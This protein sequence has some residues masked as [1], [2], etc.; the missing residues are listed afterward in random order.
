V[1][2]ANEPTPLATVLQVDPIYVELTASSTDILRL[3]QEL[4]SGE[5][6]Q[7]GVEPGQVRLR[8]P[9]GSVYAR[10]GELQ[11]SEV[12]ALTDTGSVT[13]RAVFPNPEGLLLPGMSARVQVQ[14]GLRNQALLV[15]RRSVMR[16]MTG[17]ASVLVLGTSNRVE[18]RPVTIERMAGDQLLIGTG[19]NAG[20]RIVIHGLQRVR[21]GITVT[22]A[23]SPA[24]PPKAGK[25]GGVVAATLGP[26]AARDGGG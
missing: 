19:L 18:V 26:R 25:P 16:D 7:A 3:E 12:P 14:E 20:E 10:A 1:V 4:S 21:P 15:P 9:D 13:V 24:N 22:P 17:H 8:L 6:R 11:F 23:P 5:Q 2:V